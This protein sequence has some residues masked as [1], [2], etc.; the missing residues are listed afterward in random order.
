MRRRTRLAVIKRT[1][2]SREERS[3]SPRELLYLTSSGHPLEHAKTP[4]NK[5]VR[6]RLPHL[7][8][9]WTSEQ[10]AHRLQRVATLWIPSEKASSTSPPFVAILASPPRASERIAPVPASRTITNGHAVSFQR[11]DTRSG[12]CL[13]IVAWDEA[14]GADTPASVSAAGTPVGGEIR[15][16]SRPRAPRRS[17]T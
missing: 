2:D 10:P 1:H 3:R 12:A 13:E 5:E 8:L 7:F 15:R 4:K 9:S 17:V 6:S 16:D 14:A 11:T